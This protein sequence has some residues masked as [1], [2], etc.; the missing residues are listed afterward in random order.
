MDTTWLGRFDMQISIDK[1]GFPLLLHTDLPFEFS[2]WPVTKWQ[3]EWFMSDANQFGDAWY[4]PL[5]NLNP[6]VS[7]PGINERNYEGVFLT[8]ILPSE[9][10]LFAK[11]LGD[12]FDLP[13]QAEWQKIYSSL[14][15]QRVT[16]SLPPSLCKPAARLWS[17]LKIRKARQPLQFSLMEEG[18]VEWVKC[19]GKCVGLGAPRKDFQPNA[20]DPAREAI[21]TIGKE[22][23]IAF[24][25]FRVVRRV[26]N[27]LC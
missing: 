12:D 1:T 23:R 7:P 15:Q 2:L 27:D 21:P 5:L 10:I 3:F 20:W 8:G 26:S 4:E 18:I 22:E 19:N 25:G 16:W 9:A 17:F 13:T 6:R 24:F 14:R 11:W